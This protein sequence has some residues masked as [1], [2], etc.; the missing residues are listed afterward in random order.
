MKMSG[1]RCNPKNLRSLRFLCVSGFAFDLMP[2][3]CSFVFPHSYEVRVLE[4]YSLA[5]PLEKVHHFPAEI[6]EGDRRGAWLR[7]VPK[8]GPAWIGFFALGFDSDQV[9]HGVFS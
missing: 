7:V 9:A 1:H 6:E 3:P 5:H 4:S 2:I 8:S